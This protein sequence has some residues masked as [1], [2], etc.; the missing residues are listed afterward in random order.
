VSERDLIAR[1]DE[2]LGRRGDRVVLGPG[3]DAAIVRAGG[4][5]VT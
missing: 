3:D 1:F 4:A 5:L 2:L